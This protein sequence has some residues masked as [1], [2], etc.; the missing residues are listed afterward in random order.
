MKKNEKKKYK[1]PTL[2]MVEIKDIKTDT[3]RHASMIGFSKDD[4][5]GVS[6]CRPP[7]P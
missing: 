5:S 7:E 6:E 4:I 3:I 1:K 2:R